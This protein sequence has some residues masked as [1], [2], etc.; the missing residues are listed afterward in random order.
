M[1]YPGSQG[2]NHILHCSIRAQ[3][4]N[5]HIISEGGGYHVSVKEEEYYLVWKVALEWHLALD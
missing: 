2:W 5:L 4:H 1:I 3:T